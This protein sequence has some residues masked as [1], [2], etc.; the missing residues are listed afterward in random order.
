[1]SS[2]NR[3]TGTTCGD[4]AN[5][6]KCTSGSGTSGPVSVSSSGLTSDKKT[7]KASGQDIRFSRDGFEKDPTGYFRH[8]HKK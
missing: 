8:V 3:T 5:A 1:M 7:M 2:G 4:G 6:G